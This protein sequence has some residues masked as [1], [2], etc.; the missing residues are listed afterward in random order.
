VSKRKSIKTADI[1]QV[2][3]VRAK[4]K[5]VENGVADMSDEKTSW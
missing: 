3:S 1:P 4:A 5:F 2:T